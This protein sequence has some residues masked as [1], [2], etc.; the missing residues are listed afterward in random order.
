M[1]T[2]R[3]KLGLLALIGPGLLVAATGVGAGDL[4][5]GALAGSRLGLTV[6]WAVAIGALLK[7]AVTEG[8]A[9]HQIATG[10]TWLEGANRRFGLLFRVA[11]ALYLVPWSYFTGAAMIS[12]CANISQAAIESIAGREIRFTIE[13]VRVDPATV[14][15]GVAHSAIGLV[16]AWVGGF[17]WFE[18]VMAACIALMFATVIGAAILIRPDPGELAWGLLPKVPTAPASDPEA[19]AL[20]W[21]V[22]LIGGVGGTL[23]V[24][25]Y[26]YWIREK[27]LDATEADERAKRAS[28]GRARTDLAV[29]Y[30]ATA[31][32]GMSMLVLAAGT[33]V[34]GG[35][36]SLVI[37][38]AD[39][40]GEA[41]GNA[42]KIA[43]LF[44]AWA[45]VLS[46]LLGVWQ[47]TPY[48]F[49]DLM[50]SWRGHDAA[51]PIDTRAWTYRGPL[52]AIATVPV[53]GLLFSFA[54]VQKAYG[55]Y[56]ALFLPLL[57]LTLLLMNTGRLGPFRNGWF[58]MGGLAGVLGL[59]GWLAFQR[60][61]EAF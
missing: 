43:F 33:N 12:A 58:A 39:R 51:T 49:A 55:V 11:F 56:G 27:K 25:C 9:R 21:T 35:G 36:S 50:R 53:L 5:G 22:A 3:R 59:F 60:I 7:F 4:A 37:Q 61:A 32:F 45:A 17:K 26:G 8:L 16:V 30:G 52:L 40:V 47:A 57:A 13:G 54:G 29:G 24:I 28:L 20:G 14:A 18:R 48:V 46:S 41:A 15:L 42:G 10:D 19:D 44:G 38:I 23:T 31:L 6:L 2:D 34:S 1:T